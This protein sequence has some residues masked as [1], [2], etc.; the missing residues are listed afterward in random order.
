MLPANTISLEL[1]ALLPLL[2]QA[3][4]D[5]DAK[6]RRDD[7][8]RRQLRDLISQVFADELETCGERE[9]GR[10]KER[11][12]GREGK[13]ER[14]R[15]GERERENQRRFRFVSSESPKPNL[16]VILYIYI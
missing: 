12:R 1:G 8:E 3:G 5:P 16:T 15:E 7:A 11:E 4:A 2:V 9:R 6:H 14:E 13:R 10:G